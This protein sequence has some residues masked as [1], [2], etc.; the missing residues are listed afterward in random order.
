M[1]SLDFSKATASFDMTDANL[2]RFDTVQ[3]ATATTWQFLTPT[4]H[5]LELLGSSLTYDADGRALSGT[6]TSVALD[7]R[8]PTPAGLVDPVHDLVIT[9]IA[10]D[11]TSVDDGPTSFWKM[12]EGN[13]TFLVPTSTGL[14]AGPS[15]TL[16]GDRNDARAGGSGGN[17]LMLARSA[18]A[19][20][21]G[22][23]MT[24]GRDSGA[25]TTFVGGADRVEGTLTG[26]RQVLLGDAGMV[27]ATGR[28][29]G[30]SDFLR[31]ASTDA[32]SLASGDAQT[33]SG[34]NARRAE[35]VGGNDYIAAGAG[36]RAM[37]VGDVHRQIGNTLVRGGADELVGAEQGEVISGDTYQIDVGTLIGGDDFIWG[38]GG[39]DSLIGDAGLVT[40][41]V[42]VVGGNDTI[43][44]GDGYDQIFGDVPGGLPEFVTGGDDTLYGEA[45]NDLLVGGGGDDI[46]DGGTGRDNLYGENGNDT[47]VVDSTFDG[48]VE[49][50]GGGIDIVKAAI[51]AITL[52]ENVEDLSS[53]WIGDFTGFGNASSNRMSAGSGDDLLSGRAGNDTLIGL[54]GTDALFGDEGNDTLIGGGEADLLHGGNGTDTAS[55]AGSAQGVTASLDASLPGTGDAAG[56]NF[57]SIERLTGTDYGDRLRGDAAANLLTGLAGNDVLQGGAGD[58]V[59][60]GGVGRDTQAGGDGNDK[61][62]FLAPSDGDDTIKDFGT[63]VGNDDMLRFDKELFGGLGGGP[64]DASRF[65]A[66]AAGFATTLDQRFVYET[67]TGIL[68]YDANGSA[69]GGVT[70]IATLTGSPTVTAA[71]IVII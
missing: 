51:G 28:L 61:F 7:V 45:G 10:V 49:A 56:D 5:A 62:D 3:E 67:D 9:G 33:V 15:F 11:A 42:S 52:A 24:V 32:A 12:L 41:A 19:L 53:V 44:G 27:L 47:Y 66:S 58:D 55:Y 34:S 30:G 63:I 1:A 70:V 29:T 26:N 54:G 35:V 57:V 2:V 38:H 46:L 37:L 13:D 68:R 36:N 16:F 18:A 20:I 50:P 48:V 6:I 43:W 14:G 59:L 25:R 69:A 22:D 17:D 60:V 4:A 23:A 64:L 39:H 71:D 40:S 65:I 8:P 21:A 31:I